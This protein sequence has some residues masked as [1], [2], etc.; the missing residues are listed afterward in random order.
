MLSATMGLLVATGSSRAPINL[1]YGCFI[2]WVSIQSPVLLF[3]YAVYSME[4]T[5]G[6]WCWDNTS[7]QQRAASSPTLVSSADW[8]QTVNSSEMGL[9]SG[10]PTANPDFYNANVVYLG[11]CSSDAWSGNRSAG[12]QVKLSVSAPLSARIS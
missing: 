8:P 2:S 3:S 5:G 7:C 1:Q 11:Y 10:D 9:L 6:W 4:S 12:G